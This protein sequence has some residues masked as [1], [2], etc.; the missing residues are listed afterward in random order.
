MITAF[1][2]GVLELQV[3]KMSHDPGMRPFHGCSA[4][5][6]LPQEATLA[7]C[8]LNEPQPINNHPRGVKFPHHAGAVL[9]RE[10]T[11]FIPGQLDL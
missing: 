7:T 3:F 9:T 5:S 8:R 4:T 1:I 6:T 2:P 11:V 10:V